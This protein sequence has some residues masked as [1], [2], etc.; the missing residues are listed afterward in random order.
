MNKP[1]QPLAA[2]MSMAIF[3]CILLFWSA[4]AHA[5]SAQESFRSEI[6]RDGEAG[7]PAGILTLK[8]RPAPA[9]RLKDIDGE[10]FDL[11]QH[12]GQWVFV[13]FWASWC[14]PCRREIPAI[15]A[16]VEQLA[17]DRLALAIVN[18]AED[19]DTIFT[20]LG[21]IAPDLQSLMDADGLATERW[22]PRGLPATYLVD[23]QGW[24]RYQALGG[25]PWNE[26][27]HMDF[28]QGLTAEAARAVQ[29]K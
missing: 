25:Q 7:I 21:V 28:L 26:K 22:K 2:C 8:A 15:Q 12:K 11:S 5:D 14:G 18:T 19:E 6:L 10:L 27:S 23:P 9:L 4:V 1:K 13:H 24:V 20:F 29:A 17:D 3:C 16:M